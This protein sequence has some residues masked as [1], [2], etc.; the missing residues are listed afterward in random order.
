MKPNRTRFSSVRKA[1]YNSRGT[2]EGLYFPIFF[3]PPQVSKPKSFNADK[4]D[5][6]LDKEG[7]TQERI[8]NAL[9][10]LSLVKGSGDDM[11]SETKVK[12][13][14]GRNVGG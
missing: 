3:S 9:M 11:D 2:P 12:V 10:I 13:R 1:S 6:L 5:E 7:P 8:Q 14:R 4:I